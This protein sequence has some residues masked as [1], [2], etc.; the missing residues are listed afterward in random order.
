MD[1]RNFYLLAQC[2]RIL[3]FFYKNQA[4]TLKSKHIREDFCTK[5]AEA[6]MRKIRNN[7]IRDYDSLLIRVS[8]QHIPN[9]LCVILESDVCVCK[10]SKFLQAQV[11]TRVCCFM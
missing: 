6:P 7:K 2:T 11:L 8:E 10:H 4:V 1:L 9:K 3:I 5:T